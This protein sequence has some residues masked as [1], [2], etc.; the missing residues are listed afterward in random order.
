MNNNIFEKLTE[1]GRITNNIEVFKELM[2]MY[3]NGND[4]IKNEI[5]KVMITKHIFISL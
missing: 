1:N 5:N 3:H 4:I 2:E